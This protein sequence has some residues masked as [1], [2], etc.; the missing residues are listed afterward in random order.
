MKSE[1]TIAAVIIGVGLMISL[2][3]SMT[4]AGDFYQGKTIRFIVGAPAAGATTPTRGPL[5]GISAS[6]F[7]ETH[8]WTAPVR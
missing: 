7:R 2:A 5:H 1:I 6:I 8:R 3:P 4:E